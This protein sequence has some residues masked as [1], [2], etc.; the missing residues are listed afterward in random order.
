M[1][2]SFQSDVL[3]LLPILRVDICTS[4]SHTN[5][6]VLFTWPWIMLV[7]YDKES[8]LAQFLFLFYWN[9]ICSVNG[10]HFMVHSGI[11]LW[12]WKLSPW[13]PSLLM[14]LFLSSPKKEYMLL[15]DVTVMCIMKIPFWLQQDVF[16][17]VQHCS[18]EQSS[19]QSWAIL[20]HENWAGLESLLGI[21]SDYWRNL[22]R[23]WLMIP[24]W[25]RLLEVKLKQLY[26]MWNFIKQMSCNYANIIIICEFTFR[27]KCNIYSLL[28]ESTSYIVGP[29]R[30]WRQTHFT[31][32]KLCEHERMFRLQL[33]HKG[34]LSQQ[35][36]Y[37][38]KSLAQ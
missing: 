10:F 17:S 32:K 2:S 33:V 8:R 26:S 34:D 31:E 13:M 27:C 38:G 14:S 5:F 6:L 16:Q 18:R 3:C 1:T 35:I 36:C 7:S 9:F 20:Q 28:L 25:D 12:F 21:T 15:H 11:I 29:S 24:C 37:I 23:D 19:D 4:F 30:F 22:R